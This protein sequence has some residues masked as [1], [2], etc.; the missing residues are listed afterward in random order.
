MTRA[1]VCTGVKPREVVAGFVCGVVTSEGH[2]ATRAPAL[3]SDFKSNEYA[4]LLGGELYESHEENPTLGDP[5][6]LETP[7]TRFRRMLRH[8]M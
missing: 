5:R 8:G 4:N 3:M 6:G 1:R 7:L 2:A